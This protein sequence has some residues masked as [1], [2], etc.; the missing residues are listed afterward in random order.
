MLLCSVCDMALLSMGS[1]PNARAAI[2][3][4]DMRLV[5]EWVDFRVPDGVQRW[6][7][8]SRAEFPASEG[9]VKRINVSDTEM[10]F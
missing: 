1:S 3:A 2:T 4:L 5:G 10:T 7:A 8:R 6:A 9:S